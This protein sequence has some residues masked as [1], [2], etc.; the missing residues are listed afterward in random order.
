MDNQKRLFIKEEAQKKKIESN[1]IASDEIRKERDI[2]LLEKACN[3]QQSDPRSHELKFMYNEPISEKSK[4][5]ASD[6]IYLNSHTKD[7]EL[8]KQFKN[9]LLNKILKKTSNDHDERAG[10]MHL[11]TSSKD[12]EVVLLANNDSNKRAPTSATV[13]RTSLEEEVG[14]KVKLGMSGAEVAIHFPHLKNAPTEGSFTDDLQIRHKPF[15]DVVRYVRCLRCGQWGHASGDR[16][17]NM[18]DNNPNDTSRREREDPMAYR[19]SISANIDTSHL[20]TST[21]A[22]GSQHVHTKYD[23]NRNTDNRSNI[24]SNAGLSNNGASISVR[25]IDHQ[26]STNPISSDHTRKFTNIGGSETVYSLID[27]DD[28]AC[29]NEIE[30]SKKELKYIATFTS[31][32]KLLLVSKLQVLLYFLVAVL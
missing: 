26:H 30:L 10:E 7:D 23:K 4:V 12:S 9:K 8:T 25:T 3:I 2:L 24:L 22:A 31:H 28:D 5:K 21:A 17:C 29:R 18:K 14:K 6:E 20:L 11:K 13:G 1:E 16:E 32:E 19:S 15:G 27:S